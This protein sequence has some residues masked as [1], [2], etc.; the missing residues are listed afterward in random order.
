M[1]TIPLPAASPQVEFQLIHRRGWL[2]GAVGD[3]TRTPRIRTAC[4]PQAHIGVARGRTPR[5]SPGEGT[6]EV[7]AVGQV[8]GAQARSSNMQQ[9]C[10]RRGAAD[11]RRA[12][13]PAGA[14]GASSAAQTRVPAEALYAAA[15]E[16]SGDGCR[17]RADRA[18][19][20]FRR[21]SSAGC[22]AR[23]PLKTR[24]V[25]SAAA[26]ASTL[27]SSAAAVCPSSSGSRRSVRLDAPGTGQA[28]ALVQQCFAR[29]SGLWARGFAF[30]QP[31]IHPAATTYGREVAG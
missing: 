2:A 13:A 27:L 31:S 7:G 19:S 8:V 14:G 28:G 10:A 21:C 17:L 23:T 5:P 3:P 25:A 29:C 24:P 11:C 6:A 22:A 16:G 18:S 9:I 4:R 30:A 15:S 12:P 26:I 20:N 1:I